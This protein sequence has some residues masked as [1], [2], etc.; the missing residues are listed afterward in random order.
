MIAKVARGSRFSGLQAYLLGRKEGQGVERVAWVTGRNLGVDEPE[1]AAEVMSATWAE[2]PRVEKPVYHLIVSFAPDEKL[3][4]AAALEVVERTLRD[5]GLEEHQALIVAHDDTG[6][7]HV[8]VMLNRVHPETT[9]A[10]RTSHDYARIERS[11]RQQEWELGRRLVPGRHHVMPDQERHRGVRLSDGDQRFRER[12]GERSFSEH[13][14]EVA[15]EDLRSARSWTELHGRLGDY[16]L[17]LEKRGRG[18]AL[19][20]GEH[21]VKASFVDRQSSLPQLEKRLGAYQPLAHRRSAERTSERWRDIHELRRAV[22]GLVQHRDAEHLERVEA[23]QHLAE[24]RMALDQKQLERR[25]STASSTLDKRLQ[26]VYRD[27]GIARGAFEKFAEEHGL[28]RAAG[29]LVSRPQRFGALRGRGGPIPSAVRKEATQA[30]RHAARAARN[31][32]LARSALGKHTPLGRT[33]STVSRFAR[34]SKSRSRATS[35]REPAELAKTALR[36]VNRLGWKLVARAI[37]VP[38][39]QL[40]Q[41]TLSLTKKAVDL[42][43]DLGRGVAR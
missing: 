31:W 27:P 7:Q 25:A 36:L 38:H 33:V 1:L 18:L 9:R 4:Q 40:L 42:S 8:H 3:G 34:A 37:P 14:R 29:E 6:H 30:V 10:W 32:A 11:L 13:V 24:Q 22:N 16:G 21:R 5:L 12:T 15:R 28:D 17:R 19:T 20:D 2:N 26:R 39:L 43:L 23:A 35:S 41:L